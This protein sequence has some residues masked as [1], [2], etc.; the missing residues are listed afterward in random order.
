MRI[1]HAL[2]PITK[3]ARIAMAMREDKRVIHAA[4][5]GMSQQ[6]HSTL[7]VLGELLSSALDRIDEQERKADRQA[8][9]KR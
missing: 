2:A 6:L 8:A 5:P 3:A 7:L 4:T 1:E 9:D